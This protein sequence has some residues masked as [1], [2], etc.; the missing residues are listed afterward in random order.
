MP[1][2]KS[3]NCRSKAPHCAIPRLLFIELFIEPRR[4]GHN[5]I[6]RRGYLM[7]RAISWGTRLA[8]A[9]LVVF[10]NYAGGEIVQLPRE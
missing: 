5:G 9:A 10:P 4:T 6:C 7:I 1:G 3:F 2:E 8:S